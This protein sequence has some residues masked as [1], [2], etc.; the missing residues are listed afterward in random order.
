MRFKKIINL[1][2]EF[3]MLCIICLGFWLAGFF[4]GL[5]MS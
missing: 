5:M 2:A 3:I 4:Q 1:I